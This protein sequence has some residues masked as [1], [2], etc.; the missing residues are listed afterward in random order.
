MSTHWKTRVCLIQCM[1]WLRC[2]VLQYQPL[3]DLKFW[4]VND[5][6][7]SNLSWEVHTL[8]LCPLSSNLVHQMCSIL[9]TTLI[10]TNTRSYMKMIGKR[11]VTRERGRFIS[12]MVTIKKSH[13][14]LITSFDGFDGKLI[15]IWWHKITIRWWINQI[16]Q[17]LCIYTQISIHLKSIF[18]IHL[19]FKQL[20]AAQ[21]Q[22][23]SY[24]DML[25]TQSH[26]VCRSNHNHKW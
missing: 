24:F 3:K 17:H 25:A 9:I 16:S 8:S 15:V 11:K 10:G 18:N 22:F 13:Y 2:I 7:H 14:Q 23:T 20:Y 6:I 12:K 4:K 1:E 21:D 5:S 19:L 26:G